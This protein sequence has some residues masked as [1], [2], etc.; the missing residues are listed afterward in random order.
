VKA[1]IFHWFG[2]AYPKYPFHQNRILKCILL[3]LLRNSYT[4]NLAYIV[5]L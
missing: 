3:I 4:N 5:S 2:C 1:S